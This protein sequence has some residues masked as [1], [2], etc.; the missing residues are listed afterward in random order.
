MGKR[1]RKLL[2]PKYQS[3]SWNIRNKTNN[4]VQLEKTITKVIEDNSAMIE[5]MKRISSTFD[6]LIVAINQIDWDEIEEEERLAS[7]E[8]STPKSFITPVV[9]PKS[10]T[11]KFD[12][13]KMKKRELLEYAKNNNIS[14]KK[15]MTKTQLVN[16]IS[17]SSLS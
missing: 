10:T 2:S 9:T 1:R 17:E 15:F 12:F 16:I 3:L 11:P 6:Q 5:Q 7:F 4:K 14:V 8:E 13:K